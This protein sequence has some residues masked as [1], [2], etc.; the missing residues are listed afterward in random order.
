MTYEFEYNLKDEVVI[1]IN[2]LTGKVVG[3]FVN[4]DG[5]KEINVEYADGNGLIAR[6]WVREE[7]LKLP[8]A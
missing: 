4:E 6:E 7:K 2:G 8:T 1:T 3:L 5:I